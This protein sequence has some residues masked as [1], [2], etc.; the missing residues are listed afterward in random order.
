LRKE[1]AVMLDRDLLKLFGLENNNNEQGFEERNALN[2]CVEENEQ[3]QNEEREQI[4]YL[5]A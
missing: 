4:E 3:E 1:N 5:V 2:V